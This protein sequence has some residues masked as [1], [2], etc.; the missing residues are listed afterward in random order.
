M[1][2]YRQYTPGRIY[3]Q[4]TATIARW[5]VTYKYTVSGKTVAKI[6]S[7]V[8]RT[9]MDAAETTPMSYANANIKYNI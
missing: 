3:K 6:R 2:A 1:L 4:Q 8:I 7:A 5:G 9:G